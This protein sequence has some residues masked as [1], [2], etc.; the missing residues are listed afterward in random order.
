MQGLNTLNKDKEKIECS[1]EDQIEIQSLN[2]QLEEFNLELILYGVN[3]ESLIKPISDKKDSEN[4]P[5]FLVVY[6]GIFSS[7]MNK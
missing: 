6:L 3:F 1:I 2:I 7:N 5:S 4:I